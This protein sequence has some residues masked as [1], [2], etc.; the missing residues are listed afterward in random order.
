MPSLGRYV[1]KLHVFKSVCLHAVQNRNVLG[2]SQLSLQNRLIGAFE[3]TYCSFSLCASQNLE[4]PANIILQSDPSYF[5]IPFEILMSR[6][7]EKLYRV[8][9]EIIQC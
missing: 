6:D 2:F 4:P 1:Y 9:I 7:T 5:T 8:L 3:V